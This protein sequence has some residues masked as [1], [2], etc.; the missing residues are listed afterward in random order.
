M[1][2]RMLPRLK[3]KRLELHPKAL[4]IKDN[5]DSEISWPWIV[6]WAT[7][8]E[9]VLRFGGPEIG[10]DITLN[11]DHIHSYTT[12]SAGTNSGFLKL[13]FRVKVVSLG[14]WYLEPIS[15]FLRKQ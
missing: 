7:E 6:Q 4:L 3:G 10:P 13:H 9:V 11:R 14:K 5:Q 2:R 8:N 15:S 1:N 12:G